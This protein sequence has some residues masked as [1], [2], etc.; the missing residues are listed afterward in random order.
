MPDFDFAILGAGAMA[1][2]CDNPKR[3]GLEPLLCVQA[4]L[5][6]LGAFPT[7]ASREP[8]SG[9]PVVEQRILG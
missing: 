6:C 9:P 8:V 7:A 1:L 4:L 3:P 5:E 2:A